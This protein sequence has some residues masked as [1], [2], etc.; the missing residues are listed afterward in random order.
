MKKL[1]FLV[2]SIP[3]IFAN[4]QSFELM[5]GTERVF[6]DVQ[7]LNYFDGDNTVSLFSRTRATAKYDRHSTDVFTGAYLNYTTKSGFGTTVIGRI[8]SST[9][10]VDIGIH[11]FKATKSFMVYALPSI[12]LNDELLYSWFSIL[13]FTPKMGDHWKLYSSLELFFAFDEKGNLSS[14]QRMRLGVDKKG[15]Q[16]GVAVNLNNSRF[17]DAD[18]NPGVFIRKQF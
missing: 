6:M 10:G 1:L 12:N 3:C 13:R 11:Y 14:V 5:P 17:S 16:F 9:S 18:V 2:C 8:S 15:Y 4:A 7:Y